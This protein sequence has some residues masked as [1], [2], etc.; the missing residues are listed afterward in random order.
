MNILF[1]STRICHKLMSSYKGLELLT[2]LATNSSGETDS[3]LQMLAIDSFLR[4]AS[5][6]ERTGL[7]RKR[8]ISEDLA[9]FLPPVKSSR[10]DSRESTTTNVPSTSTGAPLLSCEVPTPRTLGKFS[11]CRYHDSDHYPFDLILRVS[12][13]RALTNPLQLPVHREILRE[14]SDVFSVMLGEQYRESAETEVDI[15]DVPPTA[16]R[17]IVHHLYGCGWLC[18]SVL[19]EVTKAV[20][21][22][23]GC[24]E[25]EDDKATEDSLASAMTE[26]II[27]EA[28][29]IFDFH[30][31]RQLARHS[32]EVL[33]TAGRFLLCDLCAHCELFAAS[34]IS[35][36]NVVPAFH[37]AQLHQSSY[38]AQRCIRQMVGMPHSQLQREVF[39]DLISSAEGTEALGLFEA[40]IT[41]RLTS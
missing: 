39:R 33:A 12:D 14:S 6:L 18:P 4:L 40:F 20:R 1:R 8:S 35:P 13:G 27:E 29:S 10:V 41:T 24:E 37:F 34:Y 7:K 16:M 3:E 32:L 28:I 9:G 23:G 36:K 31:D 5:N 22:D 2:A 15:R 19:E 11:T 25:E 30:E 38:L 17:S 26:A 21:E